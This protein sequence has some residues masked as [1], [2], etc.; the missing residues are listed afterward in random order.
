MSVCNPQW[1]PVGSGEGRLSC[2]CHH[3]VR[4]LPLRVSVAKLP[5][6]GCWCPLVNPSVQTSDSDRA[7]L[8]A[9]QP[10]LRLFQEVVVQLRHKTVSLIPFPVLHSPDDSFSPDTVW[11]TSG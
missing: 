3:Y 10:A 9:A 11:H 8:F 2:A 4:S 1:H 6:E 7:R 5:G